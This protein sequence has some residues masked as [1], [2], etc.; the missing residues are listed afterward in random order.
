MSEN[1]SWPGWENVGL[2]GRGSFGAVYE[3]NRDVM[4][5]IEKAALKVISIPQ[6][7]SDIEELYSDGY[8]DESITST[9]KSHLANIIAEYTLMR[10][11]SG[12]ANIVNCDDIRYVQHDDGFGWDIFIKMELLTPL[13]KAVPA[14]LPEETVVRIAKDLCCALE[15]CKKHDIVHRDIKPQNIFL[16][17]NGDFKLGDF[18]IA[19]TVEKTTGGTKIGT[20]K[21]MAPEVY[22]NQPYGTS[23]DIYSLG[24]VLYWLLNDRRMPFMPSPPEKIKAGMEDKARLRRFSGEKL[25][26]PTHGSE[27]L[28][29][30]V[31]KA[32][33]FDPKDRFESATQM[34][35]ALNHLDDSDV[36]TSI[37]ITSF[38]DDPASAPPTEVCVRF[39]HSEGR[40]ISATT[41]HLGEGVIVPQVD[42]EYTAF[43]AKYVFQ[44]WTP[45]VEPA[46]TQAV[47]YVAVYNQIPVVT[48]QQQNKRKKTNPAIWGAGAAAIVVVA[49]IGTLAFGGNRNK[50][51]SA[52]TP[53]VG[54]TQ[55]SS[56]Q[57]K[58][59][60]QS[61][62]SS[63]ST[64]CSHSWSNATCTKP[65]TCQK[66]GATQGTAQGHSW[67]A[68][69]KSAPKTCATCGTTEGSPLA[70]PNVNVGNQVQWISNEYNA[71]ESA[72]ENDMLYRNEVRREVYYYYDDSGDISFIVTAKGN[73]GLGSYSNQYRR[74]YYFADGE[75]IFTYFE[76]QDTHRLYFYNGELM[77]WNYRNGGDSRTEDFTYSEDFLKW[78][79]LALN[80]VA[81]FGVI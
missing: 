47:D 44:G 70:A 76:G 27:N 14:D 35:D 38:A 20:Y 49:L 53:S 12:C 24:L 79:Q 11:M 55:S 23:A 16:S 30:F 33:A 32:C 31:L 60:V 61:T 51:P 45:K 69:T 71:I 37:P 18:G 29:R 65:K 48:T 78:E 21:Y 4:G 50:A 8:D 56:S 73:D 80:E 39:L 22:N 81:S 58:P 74:Y 19:K 67:I 5:T 2:I 25:P 64:E 17:P 13:S 42:L 77:R 75:L 7:G 63:Q 36:P 68:A 41:Y 26:P 59:S 52:G 46:A 34:L 43:G 28:K 9:F 10:K 6:N 57:P 15:L 66:C 72:R 40:V 1:I 3:I 62:T 54:T